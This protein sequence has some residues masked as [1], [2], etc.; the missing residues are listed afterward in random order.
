MI[1]E[2]VWVDPHEDFPLGVEEYHILIDDKKPIVGNEPNAGLDYLFGIE[3]S[4]VPI[5]RLF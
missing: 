1:F 5:V 3:K 4:P 2:K